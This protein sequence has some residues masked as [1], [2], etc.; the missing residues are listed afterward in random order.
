MGLHDFTLYDL[1]RYNATRFGDALA[2]I[3][4]D[5]TLSHIEFLDHVDR[6]AA[7]L[8][9]HDIRKGDRICVLAQNSVE[10][11]EFYGACAKTGAIAYP[12]NWRLTAAEV[13]GVIKQAEPQMLIAGVGHL[14]QLSASDLSGLRVRV[15]LGGNVPPQG[16]VPFA[17]LYHTPIDAPPEMSIDDPLVIIS[18]AA[19][20][21]VPRGAILTHRN[22]I[23]AGYQLITALGLNASDRYLVALPLFHIM[24]LGFCAGT[25]LYGG[26]NVVLDA[27]DPGQAVRL[28]DEHAVTLVAVFP[29]VLAMLLDAREQSGASWDTLKYAFGLESPDTIKRFLSTTRAHFWTG[30]GQSETTG[31]VTQ[32]RVDE[33]PGSIGRPVRAVRV[34]LVND[35]D[36]DVP[37]GEVGEIAVQ[38]PLIFSGYWR[39]ADAT[40]FAFRNGW[41]HTGDMAKADPDGYLYFSGRKPEK[42]LIKSGG[43][44]VY[45]AEVEHVIQEMPEVLGVCVIGVIDPKWGEA[46]KAVIELVPGHTLTLAQIGDAVA[47]RIASYKKP[48][49]VEF[50]EKLPRDE[51][52]V[53][54]RVAVKE[55]F[56]K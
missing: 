1:L 51:N 15:V 26:A 53:V 52:G 29:P 30:Y 16:Y 49:Y 4:S 2:A 7:G 36:E 34:R 54:D 39:D 12:I 18:T 22:L 9:A 40:E 50:V 31:L 17:D 41:H 24:A 45:P 32:Q 37:L 55:A 5:K 14:E 27:F 20:E 56:G 28:M 33:K 11:L 8:I 21:G 38:G 3:G 46:I 44:N 13:G 42:E 35:S 19:T 6:L 43:E 48:R 23:M 10:Y 47:A 25:I